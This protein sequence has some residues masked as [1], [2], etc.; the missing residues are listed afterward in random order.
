ME[1]IKIVKMGINGEGIGYY[2]DKPIFIPYAFV[3]E[4]VLV[5]DIVFNKTYYTG[6][7]KKIVVKSENRISRKQ[8]NIDRLCGGC[9][10]LNL[11]YLQQL[12]EKQNVFEQSL[13]KYGKINKRLIKPIVP[14][15]EIFHYRN[16]FKLP[17]TL[18]DGKL[19]LGMYKVSSNRVISMDKCLIHSRDL[20][21]IRIEILDLLNKFK[22]HLYNEQIRKGFRYLVVRGFE[23]NYQ[24]TLITGNN[25]LP[26]ELINQMLQ[27]DKVTSIYQSVNT[28]KF[29]VELFG[30]EVVH[31]AGNKKIKFKL[32]NFQIYLLPKAFFQ[33]N[34]KQADNIYQQVAQLISDDHQLIVEAYCGVGLISMY[35][36]DKTQRIIGIEDNASAVKSAKENAKINNINNIEYIKD[37]SAQG[38]TKISKKEKVD[39][40][41]VDPPRS[42]LNDE[43]IETIIR[44]KIKEIVYVSCNS[45]TLG[46][47]LSILTDYYNVKT[48]IPYDM[49]SQ[50]ALV[51]S[52]TLLVRK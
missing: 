43:M 6:V 42:G 51:E 2:K 31:L 30:K 9:P 21:R 46:K 48:I 3:D 49:F 37:D 14:N 7:V 5:D 41:V 19:A 25:N 24:V 36:K 15:P 34:M 4:E 13:Y 33:L 40:L 10:L 32:N 47:D 38:L 39:A 52:V 28:S 8:C 11:K 27:I 26:E 45:S 18:E 23:D 12:K 16:Q 22:C 50:T 17:F 20:E 35:L 29:N 44:S 1:N